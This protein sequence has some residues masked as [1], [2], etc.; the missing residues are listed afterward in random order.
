LEAVCA[1]SSLQAFPKVLVRFFFNLTCLWQF[2]Y[3]H[4][5]QWYFALQESSICSYFSFHFVTLSGS[6]SLVVWLAELAET[7]RLSHLPT[8]WLA[9]CAS[10]GGSRT[11]GIRKREPGYDMC[12]SSGLR[13][14]ISCLPCRAASSRAP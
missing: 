11:A 3:V 9:P 5:V 4:G 13:C 10:E 12:R 1:S 2:G 14:P 7:K 8:A 6:L